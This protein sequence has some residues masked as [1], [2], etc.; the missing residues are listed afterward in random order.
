MERI[1]KVE[2]KQI[3]LS[4]SAGTV[5]E[6]RSVFGRDIIVD[7]GNVEKEFFE[8]KDLSTSSQTIVE[9]MAWI[10]AK[11][12]D[13]ETPDLS[14]WL[15]QFG[16]FFVFQIV[17]YVIGMWQQNVLSIT[18]SKKK[19]L[20]KTEREWTSALFLL[21]S[22]ELGLSMEDLNHVTFGMVMDMYNERS[23]DTIEYKELA[24]QEDMDNF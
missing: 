5:R 12:Y 18:K 14:E 22:V 7:I 21:R 6:Y 13:P 4:V 1:V 20:R 2:D 11:E 3:G 10:M 16:P 17:H 8:E 24:T 19:N 9:N 15:E 23:N